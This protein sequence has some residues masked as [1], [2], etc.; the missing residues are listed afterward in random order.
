MV[1]GPEVA[2]ILSELK[3]NFNL[4]HCKADLHNHEQM[5]ATQKAFP[6]EVKSLASSNNDMGKPYMKP[7]QDLLVQCKIP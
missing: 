4:H 1:A 2:R 6:E 3:E 7:S 5:P